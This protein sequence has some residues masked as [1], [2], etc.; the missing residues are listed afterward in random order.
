MKPAFVFSPDLCTGC[1]ACRVACANEN[2]DGHDTGWRQVL[3]FNPE[4]HPTLPTLHLSLA[5]NHCEVAACARGC[6]A[7]A[8]Y[9]DNATGAVLIDMAKCIGCRYCSWVCP[10]DAPRYDERAG[11]MTKCTFCIHRLETARTPACIAA[12]PTGALSVGERP[13]PDAEP[14]F[15]G[16]GSWELGPSLVVVPARRSAPPEGVYQD[17]DQPEPPAFP[18]R[19][20]KIKVRAEAALLAFTLLLPALAGWFA[21]GLRVPGRLPELVPFL[22]VAAI[23][24]AVSLSHLGRPFRAWRAVFGLSTSWLSREVVASGAF[25]GLAAWSLALADPQ[26]PLVVAALAA[27]LLAMIAMD[28]VYRA[29]PRAESGFHGAEATSTFLLLGAITGDMPWVAGLLAAVKVVLLARRWSEGN[30][31][32][33]V[34]AALIRVGL[35]AAAVAAA[36][37]W[38]WQIGFGLALLSEGLDRVAF[39]RT[40][41]PTTPAA[42]MEAEAL[43]ALG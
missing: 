22:V 40:L 39:Y 14:C 43:A 33:P 4:R 35:L 17:D 26:R 20:S 12:C 21:G 38:R 13:H 6:P 18:S 34:S 32:V 36:A 7:R 23:A 37:S 41:E 27:A 25:V 16:L 2:N 28:A 31:G 15:S 24:F 9:R 42:R 30:L 10:Y 3:T 1:E 5:C 8:Y 29:V 19:P 11:V